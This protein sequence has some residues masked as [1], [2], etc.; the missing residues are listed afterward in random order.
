MTFSGNAA[1]FSHLC[2]ET[3]VNKLSPKARGFLNRFS[4]NK[5]IDYWNGMIPNGGVLL[6]M[7]FFAPNN[8]KNIVCIQYLDHS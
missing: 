4:N 8:K 6:N 1:Q 7:S 5:I 2:K 3:F